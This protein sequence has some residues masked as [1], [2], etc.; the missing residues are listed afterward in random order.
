H[1]MVSAP[2]DFYRGEVCAAA[3]TLDFL[4]H[5]LFEIMY[6]R[7]GIW[8]SKRSKELSRIF[9]PEYLADLESTYTREG[10]SALDPAAIAAAQL[11][12]FTAIRKYLLQLSCQVGGGF[13]PLWYDR[14]YG[15]LQD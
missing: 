7:L 10:E 12:T 4:R 1:Q 14:L 15:R 3:Y 8:F 13:E 6:Q 9:P 2:A 5:Q 11:R